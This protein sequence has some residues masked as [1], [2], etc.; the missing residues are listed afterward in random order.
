MVTTRRST[1]WPVSASTSVTATW[2]SNG[3]VAPGVVKHRAHEQPLLLGEL[4]QRHR[5]V[6]VTGHGECAAG[7]VED[8][9]GRVGFEFVGRPLPGHVEQLL[10][11][12]LHRGAALLQAA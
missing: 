5:Y 4:G 8:Q 12:L 3:K 1:A 2:A 11:G 9:V 6:W 7:G 10:R